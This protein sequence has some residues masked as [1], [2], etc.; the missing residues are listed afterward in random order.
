MPQFDRNTNYSW[1][2]SMLS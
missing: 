1:C 2:V